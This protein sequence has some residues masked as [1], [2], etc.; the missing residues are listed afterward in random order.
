VSWRI[1]PFVTDQ[2]RG[3]DLFSSEKPQDIA[4]AQEQRKNRILAQAFE[5]KEK[6]L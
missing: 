4:Q 3:H 5:G 1:D 2:K 6:P